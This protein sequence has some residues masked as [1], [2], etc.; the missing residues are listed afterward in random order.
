MSDDAAQ[1]AALLVDHD[2]QAWFIAERARLVTVIEQ[3]HALGLWDQAWRLTEILPVL[4]DWRADW[5]SWEHTHRLALETTRHLGDE[6]AEAV[7]LTTLGMLYRELGRYEQAMANLRRSADVFQACGDTSH[8]AMA[9][10][11]IG[12]TFRYQG[13]L[14][15]ALETFASALTVFQQEGDLRSAAGCLNGMADASRGLCRW[16]AA[17]RCFHSCLAIYD[18]LGDSPEKARA[19]V[20]YAMVFRDRHIT[21]QAQA[22]LN[23]ALEIF[24]SLA[25][26]GWEARALRHARLDQRRGQ[27]SSARLSRATTLCHQEGITGDTEV[28]WILSEW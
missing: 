10:R 20:R 7:I 17:E 13:R 14:A 12:D 18:D 3:S 1:F 9:L 8:W 6:R 25:D 22:H 26:R 2:P 15:E 27:N 21:E 5:R 16:E 11:C 4:F 23:E 28:G 24:R 19:Q